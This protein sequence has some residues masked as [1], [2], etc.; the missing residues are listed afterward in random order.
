MKKVKL[1]IWTLA[2]LGVSSFT[3]YQLLLTPEAKVQAKKT[4]KTIVDS[5]ANIKNLIEERQGIVV[6]ESYPE[7]IKRT[8]AQWE[9]LGF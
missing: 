1:R 7:N 2:I 8:Q 4:V 9:K 5:F 6:E 3:A